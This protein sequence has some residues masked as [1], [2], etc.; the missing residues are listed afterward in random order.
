MNPVYKENPSLPHII[1]ML[2]EGYQ[3]PSEELSDIHSIV[4]QLVVAGS[5]RLCPECDKKFTDIESLNIHRSNT[6]SSKVVES[7]VVTKRQEA[8]KHNFNCYKFSHSSSS[9]EL[10]RQHIAVEHSRYVD[11]PNWFMVGDSHLNIID[12]RM[13][14]KATK[15]K[16]ILSWLYTP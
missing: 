8:V 4:G 11:L 7:N 3:A 12:N 6:H 9:N 13:V 1:Y 10:Q 14:E 5:L 16:V 2:A 15:R